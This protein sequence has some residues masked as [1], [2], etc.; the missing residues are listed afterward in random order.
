M[1]DAVFL[2]ELSVTG[3]IFLQEYYLTFKKVFVSSPTLHEDT[4]PSPILKKLGKETVTNEEQEENGYF[5]ELNP[6][7]FSVPLVPNYQNR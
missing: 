4:I 1:N 6:L 2:I 7:L 3:A 5:D